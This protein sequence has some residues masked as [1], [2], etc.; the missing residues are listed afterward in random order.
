[1]GKKIFFLS[2]IFLAAVMARDWYANRPKE[3]KKPK[4]APAPV[5]LNLDDL[6]VKTPGA[7][8]TSPPDGATPPDETPPENASDTEGVEP[9]TASTTAQASASADLGE[10][11]VM[12][13]WK[14]LPRNPFEPSP[15][16][17][18]VEEAKAAAAVENAATGKITTKA[19][20]ILQA[21]FGATIETDKG[22]V[23]VVDRRLLKKGDEYEGRPIR[24]IDRYTIWLEDASATYIIPKTGVTV[25]VTSESV[26]IYDDLLK[27]EV[28]Q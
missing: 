24:K 2:L 8:E 27:R 3:P 7:S 26:S 13:A 1:M 25:T 5:A 11:P 18:L 17:K 20:Q 4:N 14:K 6:E 21:P 10:D 16:L 9:N 22:F 19:V 23:A 15:F 12:T 28:T